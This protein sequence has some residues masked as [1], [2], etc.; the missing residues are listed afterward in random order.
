MVMIFMLAMA[1]IFIDYSF[2]EEPISAKRFLAT[3]DHME[4]GTPITIHGTVGD[5]KSV[6]QGRLERK[7]IEVRVYP[8]G[9]N[10]AESILDSFGA[11][12]LPPGTSILSAQGVPGLTQDSDDTMLDRVLDFIDNDTKVE[13]R[14]RMR[15]SKNITL[16]SPI[17]VLETIE[18]I[19]ATHKEQM[20]KIVD[21]FKATHKAEKKSIKP[22][23]KITDT[24]VL[25]IK[26][27]NGQVSKV[28]LIRLGEPRHVKTNGQVRMTLILEKE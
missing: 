5:A 18:P 16:G 11:Y 13:I 22:S 8:L 24:Y 2:A 26:N 14:G 20:A 12:F 21:Q 3:K 27:P 6:T 17:L 28:D 1:T 7:L 19:E 15:N 4:D 25:T 10:R 9:H 23:S